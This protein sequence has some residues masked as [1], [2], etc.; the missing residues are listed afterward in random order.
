MMYL[1]NSNPKM[2]YA[3]K[4]EISDT[5]YEIGNKMILHL[6]NHS[7]DTSEVDHLTNRVY[8]FV[9]NNIENVPGNIRDRVFRIM[10]HTVE[11]MDNLHGI[12]VHRTPISLKA[13]CMVFIYL[14]P[15]IYAPTLIHSIG[16]EAPFWAPYFVVVLTEFIL[17]SL[18]NI[19]D[20]LEY[21]FDEKGLD[22]IK[23]ELFRI[24]RSGKL[25]IK[26]DPIPAAEPLDIITETPQS[27]NISEDSESNDIVEE[28]IKVNSPKLPNETD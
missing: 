13:Y 14:F 10:E 25:E 1:V 27:E 23:L 21:P 24:N 11:A 4:N 3:L 7:E 6:K 28:S 18:Y 26:E 9:N 16:A 5:F 22:D 2:K 17:I 20:Q 19:Q 8:Y 12:H 15:L